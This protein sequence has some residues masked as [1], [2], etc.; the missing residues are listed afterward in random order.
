MS[1]PAPS[2]GPSF[3]GRTYSIAASLRV[4]HR[5]IFQE[6]VID[7]GSCFSKRCWQRKCGKCVEMRLLRR[8]TFLPG[9]RIERWRDGKRKTNSMLLFW[10]TV[11]ISTKQGRALNS[12]HEKILSMSFCAQHLQKIKS[13]KMCWTR[14][15][16]V[17]V[18]GAA[19]FSLPIYLLATLQET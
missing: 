17:G 3:S 14:G 16:E 1:S 12:A 10:T 19:A 8:Q 13:E 2:R 9:E 15:L 11:Y 4:L 5:S 6:L 18:E 7:L